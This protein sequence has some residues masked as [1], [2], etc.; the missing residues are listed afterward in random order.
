MKKKAA[1]KLLCDGRKPTRIFNIYI[2]VIYIKLKIEKYE[3]LEKNIFTQ[4]V[5]IPRYLYNTY[6]F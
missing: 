1:R 5:L 6:T 2:H 3:F 4:H